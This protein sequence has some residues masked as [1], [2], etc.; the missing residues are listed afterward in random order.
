MFLLLTAI[1]GFGPLPWT[2]NAEIFLPESKALS[3]SIGFCFNWAC[4]IRVTKYEPKL[5]EAI[6]TSGAY[7]FFA[8]VCAIG[9]AFVHFCVPETKGKTSNELRQM[10]GGHQAK[11]EMAR[12]NFAYT[13][14]S[15]M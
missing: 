7:L 10:F 6:S 5:E 2:V 3:S 1:S 12:D 15:V 4:A 14:D 8:G 13:H 11:E 9:A